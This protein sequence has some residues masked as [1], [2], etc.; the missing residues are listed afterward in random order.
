MC[1]ASSRLAA[2]GGTRRLCATSWQGRGADAAG[3]HAQG[4]AGALRVRNW[5]RRVRGGPV[6]GA[7]L[8]MPDEYSL[9]LWRVDLARDDLYAVALAGP[10]AGQNYQDEYKMFGCCCN[11]SS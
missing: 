7:P 4:A 5:G 9:T 10:K 2:G 1:G 8:Q 11:T 3:A 6:R